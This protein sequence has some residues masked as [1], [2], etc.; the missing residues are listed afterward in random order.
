M[1]FSAKMLDQSHAD[2]DNSK[3]TEQQHCIKLIKLQIMESKRPN[4]SG[5]LLCK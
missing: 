2:A 4:K 1:P 5:L 3:E